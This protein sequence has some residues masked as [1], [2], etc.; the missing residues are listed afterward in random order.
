MLRINIYARFIFVMLLLGCKNPSDVDLNNPYD[1]ESAAF[2][3]SP[4]LKTVDISDLRVPRAVS[5]G[6]FLND[7]G[8]DVIEKG[9][10][11]STE[12]NPGISDE[13]TEDGSGKSDYQSTLNDLEF[14][15]KYYVRSYAKNKNEVVYGNQ[16]EFNTE[17]VYELKIN[18]IGNG[19]VDQKIL[20]SAKLKQ[21]QGGSLIKL[22]A[23]PSD[24]WRFERWQGD[25]Q[26]LDNPIQINMDQDKNVTAVFEEI[27]KWKYKTNNAVASSAAIGNDKTLYIGSWDASLHAINPDGSRRWRFQAEDAVISSPAIA[28]DGTIYVGSRDNY[29]YAISKSGSLKW[30]YHTS[31]S[32][33]SSP[34]IGPDGT[35]YV[36]SFDR[37]LYALNSDGSL[38][39]VFNTGDAIQSS[40]AL[41]NSGILYVGSWDGSLYA[42][43]SSNGKLVWKFETNGAIVSSPAIGVDGTV[44]VGSR[45]HHLYALRSNGS[46]LWKFRTQDEIFSSSPVIALDGTIY[47]GSYDNFFYAID[48]SGFMK[49]KFKTNDVIRG[50][51][52]I[53]S[54]GTIYIGSEDGN[55]YV[56]NKDGSQI[57]K[58]ATNGAIFSHPIINTDGTVYVGSD[59][60]FV[61]AIKLKS[62]KLMGSAW[63]AFGQNI[64]RTGYRE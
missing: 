4:D 47:I 9:V 45:D 19:A 58:I 3:S 15:K 6:I 55:I 56:L 11:W 52:S 23:N 29:L 30:K 44:Y 28:N 5:G 24:D 61:Y 62:H 40:P 16:I 25:V 54:D 2:I 14:N 46:L 7:Y 22:T 8:Y 34:T 31:S 53:A 39:W 27:V 43:Q 51:G 32:V 17:T 41:S 37:N 63:P 26:S 18:L 60:N 50:S 20:E 48:S 33:M 35:I 10:C 57:A 36:G 59:D 42:I 64:K 13:C 49:W 38:K 12:E 1:A 21:Y